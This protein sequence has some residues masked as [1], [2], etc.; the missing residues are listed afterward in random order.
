M[1]LVPTA[2]IIVVIDLGK[3]IG[4][5]ALSCIYINIILDGIVNKLQS[6]IFHVLCEI[7][8]FNKLSF[9]VP[10]LKRGTFKSISRYKWLSLAPQ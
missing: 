8:R 10:C 1:L 6:S 2:L 4:W 9:T 5:V 3:F 7:E